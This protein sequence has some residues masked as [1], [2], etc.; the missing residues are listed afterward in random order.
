MIRAFKIVQTVSKNKLTT[1]GP[2]PNP[3]GVFYVVPQYLKE[4]EP[5]SI[6]LGTRD[7]GDFSL[8]I[9]SLKT[10]DIKELGIIRKED[11]FEKVIEH[12]KNED[13]ITKWPEGSEEFLDSDH[14]AV[15]A[16]EEVLDVEEYLAPEEAD[17]G[18]E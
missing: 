6:I 7:V 8:V 17:T 2:E 11:T 4:D 1:P 9:T 14:V 16:A 15:S 18:L 3:R 13:I 5:I 10:T 12:T